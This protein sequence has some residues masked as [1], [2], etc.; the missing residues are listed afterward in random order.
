MTG[1]RPNV[2]S[3]NVYVL[4]QKEMFFVP[5]GTLIYVFFLLIE[6][7]IVLF[8]LI[9]VEPKILRVLIKIKGV[10]MSFNSFC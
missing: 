4:D 10:N 9:S 3:R 7:K 6:K 1:K 2:S 8:Y 5:L